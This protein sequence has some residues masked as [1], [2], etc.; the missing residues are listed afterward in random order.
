[1]RD[2]GVR[3]P[4]FEKKGK[5]KMKKNSM[6]NPRSAFVGS[7]LFCYCTAWKKVFFRMP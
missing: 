3:V 2:G 5:K 1:L 4:H 7:T 6:T